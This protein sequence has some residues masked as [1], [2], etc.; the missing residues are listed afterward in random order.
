MVTEEEFIKVA[1]LKEHV[2]Y[3]LAFS[4]KYKLP[5]YKLPTYKVTRSDGVDLA[6]AALS[7]PVLEKLTE[8]IFNILQNKESD[9]YID[10]DAKDVDED[11]EENEEDEDEFDLP[12]E[13]VSDDKKEE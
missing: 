8:G 3:F 12:P 11:E 1:I 2:K 7:S 4:N 6:K 13:A 5:M 9:V 10:V